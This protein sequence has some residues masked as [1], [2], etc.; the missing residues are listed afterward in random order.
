VVGERLFTL[1]SA[2]LLSSALSDLGAGPF[3]AFPDAPTYQPGYG[4]GGQSGGGDAAV[5]CPAMG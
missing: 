2:G 1:S 5:S 3:V 4:C